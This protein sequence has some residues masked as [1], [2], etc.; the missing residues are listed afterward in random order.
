MPNLKQL[1]DLLLA[2]EPVIVCESPHQEKVNFLRFVLQKCA[3][4]MGVDCYLWNLGQRVLTRITESADTK[5]L[6]YTPVIEYHPPDISTEE[7]AEQFRILQFWQEFPK[8]GIFIIENLLP[9]LGGRSATIGGD[10]KYLWLSEYLSSQILNLATSLREF[11]QRTGKLKSLLI[12][13][14]TLTLS[15]E[16]EEAIPIVFNPLPSL[17]EISNHLERFIPSLASDRGIDVSLNDQER[18]RLSRAAAGL[19]LSEIES[20]LR[21]IA[22]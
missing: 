14:A 22:T 9:W 5:S 1:P 19:T 13:G 10:S 2:K 18:D 15:P 16:L 7:I 8:S 4:P 21:F 20:G 3:N 11:S 12:V 17:L 6:I